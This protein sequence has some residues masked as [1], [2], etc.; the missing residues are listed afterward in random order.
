MVTTE[1]Q[2]PC[3]EQLDIADQTRRLT[4]DVHLQVY[5]V[6][7]MFKNLSR[8]NQNTLVKC[9]ARLP[10]RLPGFCDTSPG[11]GASTSQRVNG[12][13]RVM[14]PGSAPAPQAPSAPGWLENRP[15][16]QLMTTCPS[17]L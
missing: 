7:Q 4:L 14:S 5:A 10:K 12:V 15:A 11:S 6:Q 1:P 8:L 9:A 17:S 16:W 2:L 13:G 3:A